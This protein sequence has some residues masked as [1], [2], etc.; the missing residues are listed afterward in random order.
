MKNITL[1]LTSLFLFACNT[2][3]AIIPDT[4]TDSVQMKKLNWDI[5]NGGHVSG[6]WGWILWYIPVLFLVVVWAYNQYLKTKCKEEDTKV[7]DQEGK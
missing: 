3:P 1:F 5:I 4:T 7:T 6:N 2:T